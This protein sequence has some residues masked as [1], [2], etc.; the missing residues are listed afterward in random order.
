MHKNS[1][2]KKVAVVFAVALALRVLVVLWLQFAP[3][4]Y[5]PT[6]S[7]FKGDARIYDALA[8]NLASGQGYQLGGDFREFTRIPPLFPLFVA[9]QYL[10]WGGGVL[11]VGLCNALLGAATAVLLFVLALHCFSFLTPSSSSREKSEIF[12]VVVSH[13]TVQIA[14]AAGLIFAAYP[15]EIFNTPYVLKENFSIFL[16]VAFALAW[17]RMLSVNQASSKG[18]AAFSWALL[19]GVLLGLS[20]LSRLVHIGLVALFIVVNCW[21]LWQRHR[22]QKTNSTSEIAQTAPLSTRLQPRAA[23]LLGMQTLAALV[24]CLLV[25]SPWLVRNYNLFGQVLIS[26]HGAGRYFYVANSRSA[27]PETNGYFEGR[28]SGTVKNSAA[29]RRAERRAKRKLQRNNPASHERDYTRAAL[30]D[31]VSHPQ[32]IAVLVGARLV[33]MW[34]PV[35]AGSSQRTV[36]LLGVPYVLMMALALPGLLLVRRARKS[37]L[38]SVHHEPLT[39][40]AGL[41]LFYFVGHAAF[42]G[43]IR[44]RQFVEP[45]LILFAAY[46]WGMWVLQRDKSSVATAP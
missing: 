25:L 11:G 10:L 39:V 2:L 36:L 27:V 5:Q 9:L 22:A 24:G 37:V 40:V 43:M 32:H 45:Y 15:L 21:L 7:I 26:S 18:Q 38:G 1:V 29:Q 46:T 30:R 41:I 20:V 42:W 19:S 8:R 13:K 34:R 23:R 4:Q 31:I 14:Y 44:E 12:G 6:M 16:T 33:S 3:P 28:T 35:W 17:V